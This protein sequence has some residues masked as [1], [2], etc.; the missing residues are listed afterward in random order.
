MQRT[1]R[2]ILTVL[3]AFA[4]GIGLALL[5]AEPSM[6]V[7]KGAGDLICGQCHTMHSS[8]GSTTTTGALPSMGTN[9]GSFILLRGSVASRTEIHNFC[10]QCHSEGGSQANDNMQPFNIRAPKVH[11]TS[12][13][14]TAWGLLA[15]PPQSFAVL[16]SGGDFSFECGSANPPWSVACGDNN[17]VV[18]DIPPAGPGLSI[19]GNGVA[20]GKGHSLGSTSTV[21]PPGNNTDGGSAGAALSGGLSCTSCHDPHGTNTTVAGIN[22]YRN[23]KGTGFI[24]AGAQNPY[25]FTV[26]LATSYVGGVAGQGQGLNSGVGSHTWP[27]WLNAAS[28]NSYATIGGAA[29]SLNTVDVPM[30]R[31]C[32]QCH[33]AWHEPT[34][35]SVNNNVMSTSTNDWTRHPTQRRLTDAT[36]TSGA[37]ITIVEFSHYNNRESLAPDQGQ[38]PHTAVDATRLPAANVTTVTLASYYADS[39]DDKVF[40]VSCHFSHGSKFNDILRWDYTSAVSL[41][42]QTGNPIASNVGCQQCHNR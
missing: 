15:A 32:A 33:G 4:F 38:A 18:S 41:G 26:D 13:V 28:Q 27:V 11:L 21:V 37:G 3:L 8:Q 17:D 16:G 9:S 24:A 20:R 22:K 7:H 36:P 10:L 29:D 23:L 6:A 19:V 2:T 5:T 35:G 40:C 31:F 14:A 1:K 42:A 30:S 25:S 12:S 34:A 39:S